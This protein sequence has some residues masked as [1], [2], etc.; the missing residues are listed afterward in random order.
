MRLFASFCLFMIFLAAGAPAYKLCMAQHV[1]PTSCTKSGSYD[2]WILTCTGGTVPKMWGHCE[3]PYEA[4]NSTSCYSS[5][6]LVTA[7]VRCSLDTIMSNGQIVHLNI[8]AL[9]HYT[10]GE[11]VYTYEYMASNYPYYIYDSLNAATILSK[12]PL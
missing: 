2:S 6:Y 7:N 12:I 8:T 11:C 10:K 4:T 1:K 3:G 5:H 9:S